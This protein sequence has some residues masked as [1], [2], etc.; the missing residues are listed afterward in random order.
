MNYDTLQG[1]WKQLK[2]EAKIRWGKLTDDDF[3]QIEGNADKLAGRS[4]SAT[5]TPRN[6][7]QKEVD[8]FLSK[9]PTPT[10]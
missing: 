10:R 4:R 5:A 3:D 6:E 1:Q 7:A 9:Y 8:D 2:G